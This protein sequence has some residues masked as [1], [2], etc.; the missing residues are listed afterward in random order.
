M[1]NYFSLFCALQDI[2]HPLENYKN[3][4]WVET[5]T[6]HAELQVVPLS[7]Q[8]TF[9]RVPQGPPVEQRHLV[10]RRVQPRNKKNSNVQRNSM[11]QEIRPA[12]PGMAVFNGHPPEIINKTTMD[13]RKQADNY[14]GLLHRR[15][16]SGRGWKMRCLP[17]AFL[18]GTPKSG[19]SDLYH[20]LMIHP[21]VSPAANKEIHYWNVRRYHEPVLM[22]GKCL[23]HLVYLFKLTYN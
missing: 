9:E 10:N 6:E 15:L 4:C 1:H 11:N 5:L 13:S 2:W 7:D 19:T 16:L 14:R 18:I 21:D 12:P 22:Y 8:H 23:I 3:P 20:N 17:Y